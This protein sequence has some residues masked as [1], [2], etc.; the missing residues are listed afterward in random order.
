MSAFEELIQ[1][2]VSTIY[3][4]ETNDIGGEDLQRV[5]C[6]I[7]NWADKY[8]A[9]KIPVYKELP[10][11]KKALPNVVYNFGKDYPIEIHF[12]EDVN[13]N[14]LNV[15]CFIL[16]TRD[17][18]PRNINFG[19]FV[20]FWVGGSAPS[21]QPNTYYEIRVMNNVG[22]CIAAPLGGGGG[23]EASASYNSDFNSDF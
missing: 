7:A 21:F 19:N 12:K 17:G 10:D 11:D 18:R 4:N 14:Y 13:Q 3:E 6:N 5:L 23:D 1:K 22:R 8:K 20:K 16:A 2:I 9:D 15:W